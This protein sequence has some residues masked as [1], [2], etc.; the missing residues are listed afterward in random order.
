MPHDRP[1]PP[2]APPAQAAAVPAYPAAQGLP[3]PRPQ[4]QIYSSRPDP[5]RGGQTWG[6]CAACGVVVLVRQ[7]QAVAPGLEAAA[8]A[9][10][11]A[12]AG[13]RLGAQVGGGALGAAAGAA[14]GAQL[15]VQAGAQLTPP[16]GPQFEHKVRLESGA[17]VVLR[18][19]QPVPEGTPVMIERG[20]LVPLRALPP[21]PA[22]GGQVYSSRP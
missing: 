1:P 14:A 17:E 11:G 18:L 13:A 10:M 9:A 12:A 8:G 2:P 6:S 22:Q 20:Q 5:V 21:T 19:A 15:G 16:Q 3:P 7:V 4:A